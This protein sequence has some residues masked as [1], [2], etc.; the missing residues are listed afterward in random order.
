MP[1]L[2]KRWFSD[3]VNADDGSL[4][5]AFSS[6]SKPPLTSTSRVTGFRA[7]QREGAEII[8]E[9]L[10]FTG[11]VQNTHF[12]K[13]EAWMQM[14]NL[15]GVSVTPASFL[16]N[17]KPK[18]QKLDEDHP[19][20]MS[21]GVL[22]LFLCKTKEYVYHWYDMISWV[23]INCSLSL[24]KNKLDK[25]TVMRIPAHSNVTSCMVKTVLFSNS[26]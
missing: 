26:P 24:V 23:L 1:S 14:F 2:K 10:P 18:K 19:T 17:F 15:E 5:G 16:L 6:C 22:C 25:G 21:H 20:D 7:K 13:S 4:F 12:I 8:T 9:E 3:L 11:C